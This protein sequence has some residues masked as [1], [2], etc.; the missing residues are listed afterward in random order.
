MPYIEYKRNCFL[1]TCSNI[2]IQKLEKKIAEALAAYEKATCEY[3]AVNTEYDEAL[4]IIQKAEAVK[5]R[6]KQLANFRAEKKDKCKRFMMILD[7][8]RQSKDRLMEQKTKLIADE[9]HKKYLAEKKKEEESV[10]RALDFHDR[11]MEENKKNTEQQLETKID[12]VQVKNEDKEK[13]AD[14][15]KQDKEKKDN[16]E[17][18]KT[19]DKNEEENLDGMTAEEALEYLEQAEQEDEQAQ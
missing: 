4:E 13:N 11:Y 14:E 9:S 17:Q 1:Y 8:H 15:Q 18:E 5:G 3:I 10:K 16:Q 7:L 12:N 19:S 2:T 6:M